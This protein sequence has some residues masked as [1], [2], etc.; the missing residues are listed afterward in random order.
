MPFDDLLGDL[1]DAGFQSLSETFKHDKSSY[2]F[3]KLIFD[4]ANG[5]MFSFLLY[6][7]GETYLWERKNWYKQSDL[8]K[9]SNPI[10][11]LKYIGQKIIPNIIEEQGV[12]K[13]EESNEIFSLGESLMK[14]DSNEKSDMI[15]IDGTEYFLQI[16]LNDIRKDFKWKAIPYGWNNVEIISNKIIELNNKIY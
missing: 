9:I 3:V 8:S 5:D 11:S 16:K 15:V 14:L 1:L 4:E 12:T 13:L 7:S 6:K 2:D 10:D